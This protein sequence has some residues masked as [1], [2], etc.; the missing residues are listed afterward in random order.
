MQKIGVQIA[1][2]FIV[3]LSVTQFTH[4]D[5]GESLKKAVIE[6]N[7][8]A[9]RILLEKGFD[10]ETKDKFGWTPLMYAASKDRYEIAELLIQHGADVNARNVGNVTPLMWAVNKHQIN[11]EAIA[12][13]QLL[14]KNGAKV[15]AETDRGITAL[16][17]AEKYGHTKIINILRNSGSTK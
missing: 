14:I 3:L 4:A 2:L 6:G 15:D 5:S 12:I 1:A 7:L 9:V 17:W 16:Y 8:S 10:V 11:K 13:V